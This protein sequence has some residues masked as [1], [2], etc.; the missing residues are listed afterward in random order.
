M[1]L[2]TIPEPPSG[3]SSQEKAWMEQA[4]DD[5]PS[6]TPSEEE[7]SSTE[8]VEENKYY[9]LLV[10]T[11]REVSP[12]DLSQWQCENWYL[13]DVE[14]LFS[15]ETKAY[16]VLQ[17][18][19]G[20]CIPTFYGETEFDKNSP[21]ESGIDTCVRGI[22]IEFLNGLSLEEIEIDS[23]V[24]IANPQIGQRILDIFTKVT[25]LG[26]LQND[27]RPANVIIL[28]DGRVFL[29]DFAQAIFRGEKTN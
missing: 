21:Q 12:S 17:N 25:E 4:G 3:I 23:Q 8:E 13:Y 9:E 22:L 18:L 14:R 27:V 1:I 7:N 19:Q 24:A 15:T 20:H 29:I 2:G 28:N 5:L 6:D 10:D 26:I 11:L 16:T